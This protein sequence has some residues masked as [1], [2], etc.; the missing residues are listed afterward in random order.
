ME[1]LPRSASI[2]RGEKIVGDHAGLPMVDAATLAPLVH[3]LWHCGASVLLA[4]GVAPRTIT[5][6]LGRSQ[7]SLTMYTYVHLSPAM[8]HDAARALDA[9]LRIA[10]TR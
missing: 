10:E 8:E 2:G 7:I 4:E 9:L 3:D 6:I 1:R 5:G